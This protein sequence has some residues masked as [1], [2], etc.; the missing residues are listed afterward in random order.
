MSNN[1]KLYYTSKHGYHLDADNRSLLTTVS[2]R[3]TFIFISVIR[4][5]LT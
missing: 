5:Y 3:K 4:Y 2:Y 1:I